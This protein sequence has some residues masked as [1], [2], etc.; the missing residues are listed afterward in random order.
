MGGQKD[1]QMRWA[2]GGCALSMGGEQVNVAWSWQV[3]VA[4]CGKSW[5]EWPSTLAALHGRKWA[6]VTTQTAVVRGM[7]MGEQQAGRQGAGQV[8]GQ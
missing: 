2:G 4:V 7:G 5:A 8:G 6:S 3:V 1:K